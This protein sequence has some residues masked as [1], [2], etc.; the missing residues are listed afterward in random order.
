MFLVSSAIQTKFGWFSEEARLKQTKKTIESIIER[1][2]DAKIIIIESSSTPLT[3]EIS[4]TLS[5]ISHFIADFSGHDTLRE[6]HDININWD[7]VKSL[8]EA[9]CYQKTFKLLEG[10]NLFDGIGRV[11]KLSGRYVLNDYFNPYLYEVE[12]NKIVLT[13]KYKTQ[14]KDELVGIP[15]Q[16]MSRLWSWPTK[17]NPMIEQFYADA[18]KDMV[19]RSYEGRFSDLEH[20][21]YN[22]IESKHILEVKK[23]GVEGYVASNGDFV[24]D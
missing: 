14:Y 15:Y 3:K 12:K 24:D 7:F 19:E 9:M 5:E 17:L 21:L 6:I 1:I 10:K 20:L 8:S 18:I 11:H 4:D 2:P 16:Y 23:M 13:R 22:M